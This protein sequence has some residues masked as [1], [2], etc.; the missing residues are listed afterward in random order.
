MRAAQSNGNDKTAAQDRCTFHA[1]AAAVHSREFRD[2]S[3]ADSGAFVRAPL[4]TFDPMK[5]LENPRQILGRNTDSGVLDG[6]LDRPVQLAQRD[7]NLAAQ[8]ELQRIGQEIERDLS[9]I[10]R[11]TYTG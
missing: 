8:S 10:P 5:P 7:R 11:S 2:Q 3:E 6:K 9:H 1:R 4:R